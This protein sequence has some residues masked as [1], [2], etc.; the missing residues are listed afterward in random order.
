[1]AGNIAFRTEELVRYFQNHRRRWDEFYPSERWIFE[2]IGQAGGSLGSVL[3][4][5]C[6]V[7]GLGR[8][9]SERFRL[10]SYVGVDISRVVIEAARSIT[11]AWPMPVEFFAADICDCRDLLGRRF[12]LVAS[13]SVVDWNVDAAGILATCWNL[14]APGGHLVVSLRLTPA[15]TVCDIEMSY[16]PIWAG[17]GAAPADAERAPYNVFNTMDAI[18]MLAQQH[19]AP[20]D[21]LA[22]GYWGKPSPTA[23]SPYERLVFGVF[24]IRKPQDGA[25]DGEARLVAHLPASVFGKTHGFDKPTG[26][27]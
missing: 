9:L 25:P 3:D 18:A 12:D 17:S 26:A 10:E 5:G 4:V 7:G 16:Q 20:S 24:A 13:L 21:I 23:H 14:V 2:R 15:A 27:E 1:M 22:Y 11:T 6:A 8:A 19:P